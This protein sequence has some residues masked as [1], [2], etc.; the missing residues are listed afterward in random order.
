MIGRMRTSL[1]GHRRG[2]FLFGL[3]GVLN[4]A[5]DFAVY[6]AGVFIGLHPVL[7]NVVAFLCANVQSYRVNAAVTFRREGRSAE[8]SLPGYLKFAAAHLLGLAISTAF[9][10]AFSGAIGPIGAKAGS[11]LFSAA[12]NYVL[13]AYFVFRP[14]K[15]TRGG[16][17][18]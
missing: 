9:I 13:S 2:A 1:S 7:A 3:I 15:A 4:A 5:T 16:T 8:V 17:E 11:V 12:S 6:S 14:G 18:S 10:V